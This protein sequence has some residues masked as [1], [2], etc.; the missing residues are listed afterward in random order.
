MTQGRV[1][2]P[3]V[4]MLTAWMALERVS[5]QSPL[6]PGRLGHGVVE[7]AAA[8]AH[9]D[10]HPALLGAQGGGEELPMLADVSACPTIGRGHDVPRAQEVQQV[11]EGA[12]GAAAVP[13]DPEGWAR[14]LRRLHGPAEGLHA[15]LAHHGVG[16]ADFHPEHEVRVLGEDF[17]TALRVR[18]VKVQHRP[19][20]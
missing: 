12:R 20:R 13:H 17:G 18:I 8:M 2:S 16:D 3:G 7:A 6:G 14:E 11:G 19:R 5:G 10:D 15:L 4:V 9:V 1:G